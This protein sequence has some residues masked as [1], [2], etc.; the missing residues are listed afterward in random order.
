MRKPP[1][2]SRRLAPN[3]AARPGPTPPFTPAGPSRHPLTGG[4]ESSEG[5]RVPPRSTR[6]C[7]CG[8]ADD[9]VVA[10]GGDE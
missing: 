4:T 10:E 3:E 1:C 2:L 9:G 7:L 6:R 8:P 5:E